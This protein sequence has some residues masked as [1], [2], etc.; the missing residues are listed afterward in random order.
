L[1]AGENGSYITKL[2]FRGTVFP[3]ETG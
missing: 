1:L 3:L 2:K